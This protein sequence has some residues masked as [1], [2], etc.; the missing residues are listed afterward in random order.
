MAV[1]SRQNLYCSLVDQDPYHHASS[2]MCALCLAHKRMALGLGD[3]QAPLAL[4][5][6]FGYLSLLH[7]KSSHLKDQGV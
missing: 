6:W 2:L 4:V 5:L 1:L 7:H 3:P